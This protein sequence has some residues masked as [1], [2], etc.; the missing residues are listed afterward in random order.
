MDSKL[1][2][3]DLRATPQGKD[4][5]RLNGMY[6][7][8]VSLCD[9]AG[10]AMSISAIVDGVQYRQNLTIVDATA[11][12]DF[13]GISLCPHCIERASLLLRDLAST[14]DDML[15]EVRKHSK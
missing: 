5:D 14:L 9:Q 2:H 13:K 12:L 1:E 3:A 10:N 4:L 15:A 6:E 11:S 8:Y 7:Q